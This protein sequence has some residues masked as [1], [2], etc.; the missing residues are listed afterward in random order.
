MSKRSVGFLL[1][2]IFA[3]AAGTLIQDFRFD[4]LLSH[5]RAVARSVDYDLGVIAQ[6]VTELRATQ[7]SY[8]ATSQTSTSSL[9]RANELFERI[10]R[11]IDVRKAGAPNADTRAKYEAVSQSLATLVGIDTRARTALTQ[12]DRLHAADLVTIDAELPANTLL[13]ELSTARILEESAAAARIQRWNTYRLAMN[14]LALLVVVVV[15]LYFGRSL[16]ILAEAPPAS[17]FQMLRELP[18]P[19]KAAAA[20][21]VPPAV[22]HA[23]VAPGPPPKPAVSLT[24]AAELCGDLARVLDGRDVPALLERTA[25]LLEA[26]GLVL[27]A[28]DTSGAMLR[29]SLTHGYSEKIVNRLRPLQVDGDNVTALAYRSL[30]TQSL[31][32]ATSADPA[33]LAVPLVTGSGCVGVLAAEVRQS[34]PHPD[35]VQVA[36]IVAAQFSTLVAPMDASVPKA[37]QG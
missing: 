3:V 19:V 14:G 7:A 16:M 24:A 1:A 37:A 26:K 27:W 4:G 36:R 30:E 11:A 13:T 31:P 34:K 29:P 8:V 12:E 35:L 25:T 21:Q 20:H 5:E 23:H 18:P 28:A 2:L 22:S 10:S 17:T 33:A 9:T 6:S 32:G 15:A